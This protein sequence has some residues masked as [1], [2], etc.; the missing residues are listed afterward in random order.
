[1]TFVT[2][3]KVWTIGRMTNCLDAHLGQIVYDKDGVVD[4]CIV[5]VEMQLTRFEESW[6]LPWESLPEL[7]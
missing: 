3:S 1:M 5:L 7:P 2:G 6:P 4:C